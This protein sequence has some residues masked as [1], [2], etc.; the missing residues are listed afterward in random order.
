MWIEYLSQIRQAE[1]LCNQPRPAPSATNPSDDVVGEIVGDAVGSELAGEIDGQ[2]VESELVGDSD[3]DMAV[4]SDVVGELVGSELPEGSA[5]PPPTGFLNFPLYAELIP[6]LQDLRS[7]SQS[8]K[9]MLSNED[10]RRDALCWAGHL[11]I[12]GLGLIR[13]FRPRFPGATP[14][15][16]RRMFFGGFL[17]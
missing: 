3:G 11:C 8:R 1:S 15:H 10:L 13:L 12:L 5:E 16:T 7:I 2:L 14:P 9:G 4:G 6:V 17:K